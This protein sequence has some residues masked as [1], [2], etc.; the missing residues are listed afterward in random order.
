MDVLAAFLS[1][2]CMASDGA[3][4]SARDLYAAYQTWCY[5]GGEKPMPQ[6]ALGLRLQE[7][8]FRPARE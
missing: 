6:K 8:G 3:R 1:D 2:C 7:K 4:V 5:D